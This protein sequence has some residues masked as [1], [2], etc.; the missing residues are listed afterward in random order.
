MR[1]TKK[2]GYNIF[3]TDKGAFLNDL[4]FTDK[5]KDF[6]VKQLSTE[7]E[8]REVFLI[9]YHGR[10]F[11]IKRDREI[12]RRFEKKLQS[13]I[14]ASCNVK[15]MKKLREYEKELT[16]VTTMIHFLA[17]KRRFR[18]VIDSYIAYEYI[19][20]TPLKS[21]DDSN[22]HAV[23]KC[24]S[25]LHKCD[26]AS[27]DIHCGNF[28]LDKDRNLKVIDLSIKGSLLRCKANDLVLLNDKY[29]IKPSRENMAYHLVSI[30]NKIRRTLKK[31]RSHK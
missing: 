5:L 19:E 28:I 13:F 20:G 15:M 6:V 26:L 3:F 7:N 30:R 17:E 4:I 12:D 10:K 27:N 23:A 24:I 11:V 16:H 18:R 8:K 21:I 22:K 2:N 1:I 9:D 25:T 14:F 31:M 29:G